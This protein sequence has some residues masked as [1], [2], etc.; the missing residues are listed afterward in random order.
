MRKYDFIYMGAQVEWDMFN[1]GNYKLMQVCL[2]LKLIVTDDTK[3]S[4]IAVEND[5][6]DSEVSNSEWALASELR[7][8]L[9]EFDKGYWCAIQDAVSQGVSSS[10]IKSMITSAGFSFWDCKY[11]M[12]NSDFQAEK[13]SDIVRQAFCQT[14]DYIDYKGSEYPTKKVTIFTGTPDK[15]T[16]LVSTELL[17]DLLSQ[18]NSDCDSGNLEYIDETIYCYLDEELFNSPD[19]DIV[20]YLEEREGAY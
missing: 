20:E 5:Y 15:K 8:H 1:D 7:P 16:V 2:P 13:L 11:L 14:P 19:E 17:L 6:E 4:L 9:K 10:V 18:G 12:D 3:I